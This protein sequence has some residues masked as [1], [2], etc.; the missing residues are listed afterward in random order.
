MAFLV[1]ENPI[2]IK[3]CV[4]VKSRLTANLQSIMHR[5]TEENEK[6]LKKVITCWRFS[7]FLRALSL[8][9]SSVRYDQLRRTVRHTILMS[10][11]RDD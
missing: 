1:V 10:R 8:V 2:K 7:G 11:P 9:F 4:C 6:I 5:M 3:I